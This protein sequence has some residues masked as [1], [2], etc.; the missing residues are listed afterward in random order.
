M[1][2]DAVV[3]LL[4]AAIV[5]FFLSA[6]GVYLGA[7]ALGKLGAVIGGVFG[8]VLVAAPLGGPEAGL[9]AGIIGA[10]ATA[11]MFAKS[12]VLEKQRAPASNRLDHRRWTR[13]APLSPAMRNESTIH[14]PDPSSRSR[15]VPAC[16]QCR[17]PTTWVAEH[18]RFFCDR[19]A[20]YLG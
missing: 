20:L 3:V 5:L 6:L 10:V 16:P 12:S 19:C 7:I 14:V 11:T 9:A 17:A 13:P 15:A 2:A 8:P 1:P 18:S 4:V